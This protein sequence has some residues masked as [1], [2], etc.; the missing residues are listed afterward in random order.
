MET[1]LQLFSRIRK[2][3]KNSFELLF[4]RY[5]SNLCYFASHYTK[6]NVAAEDIVQ[7]FFTYIWQRRK[8]IRIST[9][10]KSYVYQSIRNRSINYLKKISSHSEFQE[11]YKRL[12]NTNYS[13]S[14]FHLEYSLK[15]AIA[16]C[17]DRMPEKQKQIFLLSKQEG[18]KNSEIAQQFDISIKT[19]EAYITKSYKDLRLALKDFKGLIISFS[20][21]I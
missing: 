5:Y 13:I 16:N 4:K 15:L 14:E 12:S 1:D 17:I 9:S 8:F 18:M 19:V 21:F 20:L 7:E 2:N 10:F 3:D 11:K 6:D